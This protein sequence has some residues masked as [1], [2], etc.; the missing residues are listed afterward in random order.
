MLAPTAMRSPAHA[1]QKPRLLPMSRHLWGGEPN[2]RHRSIANFY[3][4]GGSTSAVERFIRRD[5]LACPH[6]DP[7]RLISHFCAVRVDCDQTVR[8]AWQA[9]CMR[10]VQ[11]EVILNT[12]AWFVDC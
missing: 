7:F 5:R 4:I 9:K 11:K 10:Q 1:P 2:Y 3:M 12:A 6:Y 8:L